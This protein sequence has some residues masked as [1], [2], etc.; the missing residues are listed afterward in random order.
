MK[1]CKKCGLN[2]PLDHYS[3]N[4]NNVDGKLI[5]CKECERLRGSEYRKKNYDCWT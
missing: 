3:N 1:I 2:K 4:K 5:Y